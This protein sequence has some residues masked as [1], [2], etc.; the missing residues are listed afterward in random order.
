[1]IYYF[2]MLVVFYKM[3][4]YSR[5]TNQMIHQILIDPTGTELTFVYKNKIFRKMRNDQLDKTLMIANLFDP[6]QFGEYRPLQGE[7]FPDHYPFDF[8]NIFNY[9]YYWLKYY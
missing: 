2:I 5:R 9:K 6:P 3:V 7:L 1:M 4:K 8:S